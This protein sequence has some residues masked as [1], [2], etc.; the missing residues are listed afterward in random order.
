VATTAIVPFQDVLEL[1]GAHRMNVPGTVEG[2][3]TWRFDWPM[4]QVDSADKL[5]KLNELY[6]RS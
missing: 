5:R 4:V 6:G 2:N 3:W 1:N